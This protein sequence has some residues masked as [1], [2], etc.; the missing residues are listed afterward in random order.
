MSVRSPVFFLSLSG[1]KIGFYVGLI[2]SQVLELAYVCFIFTRRG[3]L[4]LYVFPHM[5]YICWFLEFKNE[6]IGK[7]GRFD[8]VTMGQ[9]KEPWFY[10]LGELNFQKIA[11]GNEINFQ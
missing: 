11:N 7:W 4:I 5:F 10:Y 3:F 6:K 1:I 2:V 8:K 9:I